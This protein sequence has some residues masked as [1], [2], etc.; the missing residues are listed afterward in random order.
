MTSPQS[1]LRDAVDRDTAQATAK[2]ALTTIALICLFAIVSR[3]PGI[4]RLIPGTPVSFV[5]VVSATITLAIVGSLLLLAPT[6]A[7]IVRSTADGPESVVDDVA[8]VVHLFVVLLAVLVAHAGL[9]PL[10]V[11]LLEGAAWVYD[12]VFLALAL[13]PLVVLVARLYVSIDP[14]S[15]LLAE[16]VAGSAASEE[17]DSRGANSRQ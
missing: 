10:I 12:V 5:A 13:P 9:A 6:L 16:K 8:S 7:A 4:H 14:L 3:L 15:E 1:T 17:T 11:P 2:L